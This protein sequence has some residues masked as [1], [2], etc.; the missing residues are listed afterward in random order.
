MPL[1]FPTEDPVFLFLVGLLLLAL[2]GWIGVWY[3]PEPE[4]LADD[5]AHE[6]SSQ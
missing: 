3:A 1:P 2:A 6:V 4:T 5:A